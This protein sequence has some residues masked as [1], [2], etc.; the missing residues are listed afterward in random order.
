MSCGLDICYCQSNSIIYNILYCFNTSHV[1][2]YRKYSCQNSRRRWVSIHLMLPF[3]SIRLVS[4]ISAQSVS[5]HLMLLFISLC[6]QIL[7][8]DSPVS[9][10]LMLLFIEKQRIAGES[11]GKFQYISCYSL[12]SVDTA[13][14]LV[15]MKFQYISC[16]SL[17]KTSC[18]KSLTMGVSIHLMLLFIKY[19]R[20]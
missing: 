19:C 18:P 5:I 1:T 2:L 8:P 6:R 9:I 17:S 13:R 16:Y 14:S 12:S 4:S 20:D 10:H 3:I 15:K 7:L 11:K